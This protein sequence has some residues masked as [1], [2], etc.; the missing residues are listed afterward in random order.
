M[1]EEIVDTEKGLERLHHQQYRLQTEKS[2][3]LL[4]DIA[5]NMSI[6]RIK[7]YIRTYI[8]YCMLENLNIHYD[9]RFF[10][11]P[12]GASP[13]LTIIFNQNYEL[14]KLLLESYQVFNMQQNLLE[15]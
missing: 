1:C 9:G 15:A 13:L 12:D 11:L 14:A 7:E 10:I 5:D 4:S 6:D 2:R 3:L 8:E